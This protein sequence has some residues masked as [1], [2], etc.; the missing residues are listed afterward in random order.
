[1]EK[2]RALRDYFF[3]KVDQLTEE[4][5]N[6]LEDHD[7]KS[8]YASECPEVIGKLKSMNNDFHARICHVFVEDEET[9]FEEFNDW[10]MTAAKDSHHVATPI[11]YILRE[12]MR[13]REQYI[14]Y[15][16]DFLD[17]YGEE[18]SRK[19]SIA[20][21]RKLNRVFDMIITRFTEESYKSSQALL[22]AQQE[23][24]NELSS[25]IIILKNGTALLPLVGDIDTAR[26]KIVLENTLKQCAQKEINHLFIDLSGVV[27]ID[28]MVANE[29]F[30]LIKALN[31]IGVHSTL[32]GI[33]PEIAVTAMHLGLTFDNIAITPTLGQAIM[34]NEKAGI[35]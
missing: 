18:I 17:Y 31:L 35:E 27:M 24:I 6:S 20:W 13:V 15:L 16:N 3:S 14:D 33:R 8:V 11:H 19:R 9:F 32:S 22:S 23:I 1:M 12:F 28:T 5:Y 4:W 30:Q 34:L 2:N 26:A 21:N 29:I 10:I 7:P 25:P